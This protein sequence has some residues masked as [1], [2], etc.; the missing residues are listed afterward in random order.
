MP[1]QAYA[2]EK[3]GPK[4]LEVS[5][6]GRSWSGLRKDVTLRLDDLTIG[7]IPGWND[8]SAG[9]EFPLPD[10]STLKVQWSRALT[11]YAPRVLRDG[12]PLPG[13]LGDPE[14]TLR[15]TA[16]MLL[17]VAVVSI[18]L[19][20]SRLIHRVGP[21][22][23]ADAGP[24]I[25]GVL[26]L[27][28]AFFVRRGSLAAL[29]IAIA[30]FVLDSI[31]PLFTI[32]R[33]AGFGSGD[34][35]FQNPYSA[36]MR[37][38]LLGGMISGVGAIR[39][40]RKR[41][42]ASMSSET[43][44]LPV[45]RASPRQRPLTRPARLLL[46]LGIPALLVAAGFLMLRQQDMAEVQEMGPWP[47]PKVSARELVKMDLS[48]LGLEAG[49]VQS[50]RD[51]VAWARGGYEDGALVVYEAGAESVVAVWALRYATKQAAGNDYR[52]LR[53]SAKVSCGPSTVTTSGNAGVIHC[54][55]DNGYNKAFWNGQW[56]IDIRAVTL[57]GAE[58]TPDVLV[59][60]VRDAVAAHW[61]TMAQSSQ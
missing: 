3:G 21:V 31:V 58:L 56:I 9:Q 32:T 15:W 33:P 40:I 46:S 7:T 49:Q 61:R 55:Y 34:Y 26:F 59:D 36:F 2:L 39:A 41:K 57:E 14:T 1:S 52:S 30:A 29:V 44:S 24:L 38:C 4:R 37:I 13:S 25:A 53:A 43:G 50:A 6:S 8:L 17:L 35:W 16:G 19:G 45:E 54:Q 60:Q 42:L 47:G 12:Q 5:W 18:A 20:L 22:Q 27:L 11:T 23:L 51:Q 48:H 28:L 10:G